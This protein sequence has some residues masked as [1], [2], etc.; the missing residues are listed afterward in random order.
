[1]DRTSLCLKY[2][3]PLKDKGAF[4]ESVA[5]VM[6][7]KMSFRSDREKVWLIHR[8]PRRESQLL[9]ADDLMVILARSLS[10]PITAPLAS[11]SAAS[12]DGTARLNNL[13]RCH[14]HL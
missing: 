4:A 6:A 12:G 3:W 10:E 13:R 2:S 14:I 11:P 5:E 7:R 8:S 1:M 9:S